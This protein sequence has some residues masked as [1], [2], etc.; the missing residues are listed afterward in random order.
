M[1]TEAPDKLEVLALC[2]AWIGCDVI[3][4]DEMG[5]DRIG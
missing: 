4:W 2:S 1:I 5:F 3:L